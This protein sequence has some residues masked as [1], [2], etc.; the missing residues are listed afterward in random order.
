MQC[1]A[2]PGQCVRN[3]P[4]DL[5]LSLDLLAQSRMPELLAVI[6]CVML[7]LVLHRSCRV[8]FAADEDEPQ[9][10]K[11]AAGKL[12]ELPSWPT[13]GHAT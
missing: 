11:P 3:E 2:V 13:E 1:W 8:V 6:L 12:I 9:P 4:L 7:L 5:K 10:I